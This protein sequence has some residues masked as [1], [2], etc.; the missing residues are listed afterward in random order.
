MFGDVI[1]P[2]FIRFAADIPGDTEHGPSGA[3]I[4]E[5]TSA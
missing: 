5:A 2:Q 4:V 3:K 1:P